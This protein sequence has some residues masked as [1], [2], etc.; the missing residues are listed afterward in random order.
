MN[1]STTRRATL[2]GALVLLAPAAAHAQDR[3]FV[4]VAQTPTTNV[5]ARP[6]GDVL[7]V[8][9]ASGQFQTFLRACEAAGYQETLRGEGPFT[10]FAPTDAAF[11]AM[12]QREVGRLLR[13]AAHEEL[14]ALLAY[15]VVPERLTT[16]S[17]QG[18]VVRAEAASGYRLVIDAR[19]G[20][21]VNDQLV[22]MPDLEARNGVIQGVNT[23]LTPPVL[24]ASR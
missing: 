1:N 3:F 5:P 14:L 22:V 15:H 24:V 13:P 18:R 7:E 19:D 16:T 6:N 21:R 11:R 2:L 17:M 9:A 8:A 10:I 20:L 23:V 4:D 12:G